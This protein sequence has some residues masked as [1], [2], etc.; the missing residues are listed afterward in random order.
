MPLVVN[1]STEVVH[2]YVLELRFDFGHVYWDRAG[3]IA[4]EILGLEGWD[5]EQIDINHCRLSRRD[6]NIA[7]NFGPGKLDL[8]QTQSSDIAE[9]MPT[10][11]FGSLAEQLA[12]IVVRHLE[13]DSFPRIGFRTWHLYPTRDRQESCAILQ[14]LE[15][16]RPSDSAMRVLGDVS[17]M[18]YRIVVERQE[19]MVRIALAP[20][21]QAIDLPPSILRAAKTKAR[22]LRGDKHARRALV[23]KLKAERMIQNY[24]QFGVLLD[25]DAY[26]EDPPYPDNLSAS[27]FLANAV[28]DF[29]ALKT[30]VLQKTK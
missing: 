10:G 19:H 24:P 8:S 30:I 13:L 23:D 7:F 18:S 12:E 6:L 29:G 22:D 26:I 17:E 27:D 4:K 15:L 16:F 20:F 9:L 3:R 5:F 21:E 25:L 28:A 14:D 11:Q 2:R 1:A